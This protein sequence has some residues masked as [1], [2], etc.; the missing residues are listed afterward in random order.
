MDSNSVTNNADNNMEL[1]D[2]EYSDNV[3][4]TEDACGDS[5]EWSEAWSSAGEESDDDNPEEYVSVTIGANC[6][7]CQKRF[8]EPNLVYK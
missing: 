6:L 7:F 8:D 2:L 1:P 4:G 3:H 5:N